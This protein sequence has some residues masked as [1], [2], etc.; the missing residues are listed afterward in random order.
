[1]VE[2]GALTIE[3]STI[4]LADLD[5]VLM[6]MS[7]H[8]LQQLLSELVL[9]QQVAEFTHR[10]PSSA[11]SRRRSMLTKPRIVA[12]SYKASSTAG[13]DRLTR[14]AENSPQH[15]LQKQRRPSTFAAATLGYLRADY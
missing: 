8:C 9:L 12:E 2:D 10:R 14:P 11:G 7:V 3:A 13:S 5:A 6:K 1:L 4:A 15:P